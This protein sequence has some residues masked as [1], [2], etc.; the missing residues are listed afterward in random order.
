[1]IFEQLFFDNFLSHTQM[2]IL[3]SLSVALIIVPLPKLLCKIWLSNKLSQEMVV[4][5]TL[6]IKIKLEGQERAF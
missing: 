4:Q 3:P 5:I 6:L 1:M 2:I